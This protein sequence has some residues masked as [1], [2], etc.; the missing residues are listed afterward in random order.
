MGVSIT[1]LTLTACDFP[2]GNTAIYLG[3][4]GSNSKTL[5]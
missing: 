1:N 3:K 5:K 2:F 4:I